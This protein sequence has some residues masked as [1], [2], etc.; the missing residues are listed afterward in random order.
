MDLIYADRKLDK[1]ETDQ[2]NRLNKD[3]SDSYA[4]GQISNEQYTHLKNEV[5]TAYQDIFKKRIG[6][7]TEQDL[8]TVDKIRH[9]IIDAYNN[10][11][12][13]NE[14]YTNLKNEISNAYQKIFKNGI[15]SLTDPDTEAI[16][17]I[18]NDIRDAYADGKIT[19]M[20]YKLLNEK[21]DRLDKK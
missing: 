16:S 7:V 20:H 8:E 2:S 19:E 4:A 12:L 1:N 3:I 9:D 21:S 13:S 18:K 5:S 15:E 14:H 17:T 11:K 10:G 6:S